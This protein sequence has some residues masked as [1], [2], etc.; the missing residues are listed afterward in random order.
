[1]PVTKAAVTA[2]GARRIPQSAAGP[3]VVAGGGPPG[4]IGGRPPS[5]PRNFHSLIAR[6]GLRLLITRAPTVPE[7]P[8]FPAALAA[9]GVSDL[10]VVTER[11]FPTAPF[12][13]MGWLW[14]YKPGT[15]A[16]APGGAAKRGGGKPSDGVG[17]RGGKVGGFA[18][19]GSSSGLLRLRRWSGESVDS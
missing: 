17:G 4:V 12:E 7:L 18:R 6:N 11:T 13:A 9:A 2:P 1:M 5:P 10:V 3:A 14:A 19:R 16:A 15:A 8:A